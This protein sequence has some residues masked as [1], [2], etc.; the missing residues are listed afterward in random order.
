VR[1]TGPSYTGPRNG[2]G[3][4]G[5]AGHGSG[6]VSSANGSLEA[7]RARVTI[8]MVYSRIA[9]LPD[10]RIQLAPQF[11]REPNRLPRSH[12]T[13]TPAARAKRSPIPSRGSCDQANAHRAR[14]ELQRSRSRTGVTG[15]ASE[16]TAGRAAGDA[17]VPARRRWER[18]WMGD[19]S[20]RNELVH[21]L[22]FLMC[23]LADQ[24]GMD[25]ELQL[26]LS[27]RRPKSIRRCSELEEMERP[28]F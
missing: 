27:F 5:P 11:P 8:A 21:S 28:D 16:A 1:I 4:R 10:E 23:N 12:S 2:A 14:R 18:M 17:R 25:W 19:S 24:I 22:L 13:S 20:A 26:L 3:Q 7:R 9:V 6:S 15:I